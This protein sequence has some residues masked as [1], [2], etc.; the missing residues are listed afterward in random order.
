MNHPDRHRCPRSDAAYD[1]GLAMLF[2]HVHDAANG[3]SY[4]WFLVWSNGDAWD[5]WT[6]G[7]SAPF[8]LLSREIDDYEACLMT[9]WFCPWCGFSLPEAPDTESPQ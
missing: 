7:D 4:E 2:C 5:A 6:W 8:P 9:V 1:D 3:L